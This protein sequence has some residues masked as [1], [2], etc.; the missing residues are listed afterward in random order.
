M[1]TYDELSLSH[2]LVTEFVVMFCSFLFVG[3]IINVFAFQ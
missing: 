2:N 1:I 3:Q